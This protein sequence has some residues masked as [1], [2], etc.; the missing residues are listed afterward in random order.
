M[1]VVETAS[2]IFDVNAVIRS[3]LI[4]VLLDVI[5]DDCCLEVSTYQAKVFYRV[6]VL[7]F[8][9]FSSQQMFDSLSPIDLLDEIISIVQA[10]S[11][12]QH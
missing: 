8:A 5:Y 3:G 6:V 12:V 7:H 9:V 2:E 11:S 10:R 1:L 4:E